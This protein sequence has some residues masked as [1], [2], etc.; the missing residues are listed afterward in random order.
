MGFTRDSFLKAAGDVKR[1]TRTLQVLG[2]SITVQ[3]LSVAERTR[4]ELAIT[5]GKGKNREV[6]VKEM[7]EKL[8]QKTLVADDG[9]LLLREEDLH[10]LS[11]MPASVIELLFDAARELSGMTESSVEDAG[12]G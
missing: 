8:L 1:P 5:S 6:S 4:F 10:V 2:D 7:R 3:G 11:A 9:S 12:N